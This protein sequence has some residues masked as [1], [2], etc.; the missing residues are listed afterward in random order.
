MSYNRSRS[1]GVSFMILPSTRFDYIVIYL[2]FFLKSFDYE[3]YI[4]HYSQKIWHGI[5][6]LYRDENICSMMLTRSVRLCEF[7]PFQ[8]LGHAFGISKMK[9]FG[10]FLILLLK[11]SCLTWP[12]WKLFPQN[13]QAKI[14]SHIGKLV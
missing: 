9:Q 3:A 8:N 14:Q 12:L 6:I 13:R 2:T 4:I 7:L 1:E 5:Y 11:F 10:T